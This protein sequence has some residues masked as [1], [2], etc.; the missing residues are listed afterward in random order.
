MAQYNKIS[1]KITVAPSSV[2][3][4]AIP[5]DDPVSRVQLAAGRSL[6]ARVSQ[7]QQTFMGLAKQ[8]AAAEGLKYG[9]ASAPS[10]EQIELA[11]QNGKPITRDDLAGSSTSISIFEQAARKGA[12]A[13]TESRFTGAARRALTDVYIDATTKKNI[14]PAQLQSQ[15]D[16]VVASFSGSM[17]SVDPLSGAK[18]DASL[19]LVANGMMQTY[20]RTFA[21]RQATANKA[22]AL[23]RVPG[24]LEGMKAVLSGGGENYLT[25][26]NALKSVL[27]NDLNNA[28][29][30]G[31]KFKTTMTSVETAIKTMTKG[32]IKNHAVGLVS[33]PADSLRVL[34]AIENK[35]IKDPHI[36]TLLKGLEKSDPDAYF[37][38]R[39]ELRSDFQAQAALIATIENGKVTA[40]SKS[41]AE[42]SDNFHTAMRNNDLEE[43]RLHIPMMDAEAAY[44]ATVALRTG[45][46]Q[47][48]GDR[49]VINNIETMLSNP[50][51]SVAEVQQ[52]ISAAIRF[53]KI[54]LGE[55]G[56]LQDQLKVLR[57]DR[58][59]LVRN[60]AASALRL[61]ATE[62]EDAGRKVPEAVRRKRSIYYEFEGKL[63]RA[64]LVDPDTNPVT[65][66]DAQF[67]SIH[68]AET[69]RILKTA[70]SDITRRIELVKKNDP[71]FP[72]LNA[73]DMQN[74]EKLN[75]LKAIARSKLEG[76]KSGSQK[77]RLK[78][79]VGSLD[80]AIGVL[81]DD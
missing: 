57:N 72:A 40:L 12:L 34:K 1:N 2:P 70:T 27:A 35:T 10:Q 15:L 49:Q 68:T 25:Q 33:K 58:V 73:A 18:I 47:G 9:A 17:T 26:L 21:T 31:A 63:A 41:Q 30:G 64:M 54:T 5:T 6:D 44:N 76:E 46:L 39:G 69:A 16:D 28:G 48:S 66:F 32:I 19:S 60:M 24:H 56:D 36:N 80:Q 29:V 51:N 37:K 43:A 65:F 71:A 42:A 67:E 4:V 13:V 75:S 20:S 45:G 14:D 8:Q 61:S 53:N 62:L 22:A 59:K 74:V 3:S 23:A 50:A 81:T 11:E 38:L 55:A 52:R 78:S 77:R 7:L 79:L